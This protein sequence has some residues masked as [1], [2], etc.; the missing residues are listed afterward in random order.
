MN[1]K[2]QFPHF[3]RFL[4]FPVL[5]TVIMWAA[6]SARAVSGE[7]LVLL[8]EGP[9]T[10][11]IAVYVERGIGE[12]EARRA[13]A[14]I[15]RLNTPGGQIDVM[16]KIIQTMRGSDTPVIVFVTPRGALAGSAGAVIT[17][18]GHAAAM[19]PETAIG[20][21]SPVGGGGE[22]LNQTLDKKI[23]EA[24]SASAR[25]L[26]ERR[27]AKAVELATAMIN[28]AKAVSVSEARQAGLID[29]VAEDTGELL[30][31]MDGFEVT[32]RDE[33]R[34]L[35]TAGAVP[36]EF[37]MSLV[38]QF[39][40]VLTNP[41]LIS[42]LL[43]VGA[44]AILIELSSPGGWVAGFIGVVCLALAFYG[45][46]VLPVNWFGLIFIV[47]AFVLFILD[48]KAPTHGGLT[49]AAAASLI[50]GTLVLFNSPNTPSFQRVS[51]PLVVGTSIVTATLFL[52][53]V[54][55]AV[56]ARRW[57]V[58]TGVE[59]LVGQVG[60]TRAPLTPSGMVQVGGELW[61]AESEGGPI[62]AGR[63]VEVVGVKGLRL[64][65]RPK[66]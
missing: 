55:M 47:V 11:A 7:V 61:S 52:F 57:P 37:P 25:S 60:E 49:I 17:L 65:V 33:P 23:K 4:C 44:Q 8:V 13:E 21:A 28:D 43:L 35:R 41:N 45:L 19:S 34:R 2:A 53:V 24:L 30:G 1:R 62:E 48:I 32:V 12:A 64:R 31:Q 20:A 56:R 10:Q 26:T 22:D 46:S 42:V 54:A 51:V 39:L 59:T 63:K 50:A 27:G 3:L 36:V 40:H 38:E 15:V 66:E 5:L 14:V 6:G 29:F 58:T 16:Q 9:I 18:A